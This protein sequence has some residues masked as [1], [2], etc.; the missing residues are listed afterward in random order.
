[1]DERWLPP[2]KTAAVCFS[3]DDIHPGTSDDPYEAGGDLA[4]GA[5]GHVTWLIDRHPQLKVTL[6]TTADW[7]AI[8]PF[9][10]FPKLARIPGLRQLGHRSRIRSKGTMALHRHPQFVDFLRSQPGFEVALH[11][12]HHVN[13]VSWTPVEF[14]DQSREEC[15]RMLEE[16][17]GIFEQ[18]RLPFALGMTPP[19]WNAP[20]PLLDAMADVGLKFVASARDVLSPV[21]R[22]AKANM[23]GLKGVG[24]YAPELIAGGRL[25]HIPANFQATSPLER[26][27]AIV[28]AGGLL[29]IKGHIIKTCFGHVALDGIDPLYRNYL[30][31]LFT[32]LKGRFGDRLWWTSMGEIA[33]RMMGSRD[34]KLAQAAA[35][36]TVA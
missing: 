10:R 27:I 6:F 33:G 20:A 28:E 13:A 3:I 1:M 35:D 5:L 24:L 30:D 12:L 22:S 8:R 29:S 36:R 19:G 4:R 14:Q 26:A 9:S 11:G 7:R 18:A 34:K 16:A 25:V 2:G 32:N 23:S 15:R 21:E 31:A 17:I